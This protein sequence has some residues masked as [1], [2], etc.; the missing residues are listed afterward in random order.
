MNIQILLH[1]HHSPPLEACESPDQAAHSVFSICKSGASTET[2]S[3]RLVTGSGHKSFKCTVKVLTMGD[4]SDCWLRLS[5]MEKLSLGSFL[6]ESELMRDLDRKT[7]GVD[8]R[9]LFTSPINR[10]Q[11]PRNEKMSHTLRYTIHKF[12]L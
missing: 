7:S 8:E 9:F 12:Q 2:S 11:V 4:W 6:E 5:V 1:T 3:T 10:K